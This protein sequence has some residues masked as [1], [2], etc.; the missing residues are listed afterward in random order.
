[1][2]LLCS[3]QSSSRG[4]VS[5]VLIFIHIDTSEYPNTHSFFCHSPEPGSYGEQ[6]KE[7]CDGV[8]NDSPRTIHDVARHFLIGIS[9]DDDSEDDQNYDVIEDED[10]STFTRPRIS[11]SVLRRCVNFYADDY[12]L[13]RITE[14]LKALMQPVIHQEPF[15]VAATSSS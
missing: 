11:R 9:G 2:H 6:V 7:M 3:G 1:M 8:L 15:G 4:E 12:S 14:T 10:M 13:T 5:S